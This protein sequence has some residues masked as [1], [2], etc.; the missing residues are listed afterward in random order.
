MKRRVFLAVLTLVV[1]F[2]PGGVMAYAR[3]I[4]AEIGSPFVA[5]GKEM[6]AG[7]ELVFDKID[8]KAVLSEVWL[9]RKDGSLLLASKGPI[10]CLTTQCVRSESI[11]ATP[12]RRTGL[13]APSTSS[14]DTPGRPGSP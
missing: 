1:A 6:A 4:K 8:G 10:G 14:G 2:E 7:D 3:G 9:P 12:R 13:D 5:N 11:N